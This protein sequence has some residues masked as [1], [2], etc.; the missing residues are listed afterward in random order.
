M[1]KSWPSC[2]TPI[3]AATATRLTFDTAATRSPAAITGTA[4]GRSTT[5]KRCTR[6]YPI[7]VAASATSSGTAARPSA[8]TRTSS[9]TVYTVSATTTLVGSRI[10]VPSR[11][12]SSTNSAIDGIV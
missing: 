7:A 6:W 2:G 5:K 8:T 1:V 3:V 11:P 12:G 10:W 9:A 4:I